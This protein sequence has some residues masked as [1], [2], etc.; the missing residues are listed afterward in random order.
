M[1]ALVLGAITALVYAIA[2]N[3]AY[4]LCMYLQ[5]V[6]DRPCDDVNWMGQ[7]KIH[8]IMIIVTTSSLQYIY[9]I[10]SRIAAVHSL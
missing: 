3:Y 9:D 4:E 7:I 2:V 5:R 1:R 8:L 10:V 6:V